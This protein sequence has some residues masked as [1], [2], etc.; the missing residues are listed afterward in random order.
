MIDHFFEKSQKG[1]GST[2]LTQLFGNR[3]KESNKFVAMFQTF[4][5]PN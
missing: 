4:K 3:K 5:I 2:M 1:K